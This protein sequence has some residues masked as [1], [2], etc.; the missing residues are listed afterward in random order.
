[1]DREQVA[2]DIRH[3]RAAEVMSSLFAQEG[4]SAI[5]RG[6]P[7]PDFELPRLGGPDAGQR[8]RLSDHFAPGDGGRPV[9]LV[10]GS[11]T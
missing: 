9:A 1:M 11:Y 6:E 7:A 2:R 5:Q 10:F 8:V 3:P 4:P